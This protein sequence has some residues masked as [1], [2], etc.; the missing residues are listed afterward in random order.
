MEPDPQLEQLL[1]FLREQRGFDFTGYKRA[2]LTR[3]IGHRM[4]GLQVGSFEDYQDYL[5]VHPEEFTLLFNTILINTTDFF[6][7]TESWDYMRS[8]IVPT[9]L[10]AR[11]DRP[12]RV[13]SA[14]CASGE[15][16]Y[17]LAMVLADALGQ[18]DFRQ[19]VKIYATD[20][21]EEALAYARAASYTARE[22]RGLSQEQLEAYFEPNGPRGSRRTFHKALR[23][24]VIFGRNDLIQDAP[25]S[26]VDLLA[27]RNT[28][29]YFNTQAQE[30]ILGRLRFA[31]NPEGVLFLGKAELLHSHASSFSPMETR[32]RFF[33]KLPSVA[34]RPTQ[35]PVP[36]RPDASGVLVPSHPDLIRELALLSSP[37]AQ[38]LIDASGRLVLSN[39]RAELLFGVGMR[40]VGRRFQ[41]LEISYR[42]VEL[43]SVI[44]E[45]TASGHPVWARELVWQR[46]KP[47]ADE[48]T[49][50]VQVVPLAGASGGIVG[51]TVIFNDV[52][53]YRQMQTELEFA[54][55][56]L[57][58]ALRELQSSHEELETTNEELQSTVEEL[59]TTNE[60]LQS[61]NEELET[62]N[63]ELQSM[64]DELQISNEQLRH[65]TE[66]VLHL[67]EFLESILTSMRAGVAV[68]DV[69]Q[70]VLA[71]NDAA[72]DLWGV[73]PQE[74][75]GCGL[76]D[77]DMGL[78]VEVLRPA[79][80][81]TLDGASD[82]EPLTV[83]AVNRR[84]RAVRVRVSVSPLQ[85]ASKTVAGAI[86][87]MEVL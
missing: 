50:D 38:M 9:L 2:S 40:D 52:T 14:G 4:S 82:L 49:F 77:I 59:E 86:I 65:R 66:E 5:E 62:M 22:L 3:R 58:S 32:R 55:R 53:R 29:M 69:A 47:E 24:S 48:L 71:W 85:R 84:G 26:H 10:A 16:A 64:N 67:N 70:Q 41:D 60:E 68:V 34:V 79:L 8:E 31:L 12:I 21:D 83:D 74:A 6:R 72:V 33:R 28:L 19:R 81:K 13:W 11:T 54:N 37:A 56:Q 73:R 36:F 42:P 45:A 87:L 17:S 51:T 57:E 61:T 25:I 44:D 63:E 43:R 30:R 80:R 46:P 7:D 35:V 78:P 76:Q 23:R 18:E 75:I 39:H 15:E 20:V 27:C 1:V